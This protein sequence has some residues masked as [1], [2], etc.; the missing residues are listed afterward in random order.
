M[1]DQQTLAIKTN[2]L[3][4][5]Y[6]QA[7]VVNGLDLQ[8]KAGQCYG[9]LGPNGAGKSTTIHMLTT[10]T[11]PS[12]GEAWIA[13]QSIS[14]DPV[15]IRGLV[16]LVFQD[17][18]LDRTMTVDENLQFAAALYG[19]TKKQAN[20]RIEE[21]L[22]VFNL[23]ARRNAKL[24]A[25]SGGQRRAVDIARGVLHRPQVLF[26]DEPTIGLDLPNRRS[27][28]RF[29]EQLRRDHG[30]TVFLTTHYLEEA[31]AC[32]H[33]D[34]I[35]RG[36]LQK[37]GRPTDLMRQLAAYVLEIECVDIEHVSSRLTPQ[38]GQPIIEDEQLSYLIKDAETDLHALQQA[39]GDSINAMRW[40]KPNLNDVYLWKV[41]PPDQEQAA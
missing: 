9:L 17:S 2:G 30:M 25:L 3:T 21:L 19:M 8:V 13:N 11:S 39:L 12:A 31:V 35:Q 32:D 28:W 34:F 15:V 26:L 40:R 23:G 4:K 38:F 20:E 36:V 22:A 14:A 33:V 37:G 27:I 6:G 18:A 5:R 1:N 24:L 29:V 41:C 16:G 10:M 7:V